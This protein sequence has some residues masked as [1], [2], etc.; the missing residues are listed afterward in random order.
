VSVESFS[1]GFLWNVLLRGD[2]QRIFRRHYARAVSLL[3]CNIYFWRVSYP[4]PIDW[5]HSGCTSRRCLYEKISLPVYPHWGCSYR[6]GCTNRDSFAASLLLAWGIC[7]LEWNG[8][9]SSRNGCC[10]ICHGTFRRKAGHLYESLRS[11]FWPRCPFDACDSQWSHRYK[12]VAFFSDIGGRVCPFIGMYME[13]RVR[14]VGAARGGGRTDGCT[15]S[16]STC[17][18]GEISKIQHPNVVSIGDFCV[19]WIRRQLEQ[20]SSEYIRSQDKL[21]FS[22]PQYIRILDRYALWAPFDWVDCPPCKLR[23]LFTWEHDDCVLVYLSPNPVPNNR[24]FVLSYIWYWVRNVSYLFHHNGVCESYVSR[25]GAPRYKCS[26]R[27]C[28][29][30]CRGIPFSDWLCNGPLSS[31]SGDV[32]DGCFYFYDASFIFNQLLLLKSYEKK[33]Y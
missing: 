10:L 9:I 20:L 4:P 23:A 5:I 24:G 29:S 28:W 32:G 21:L 27:I 15:Y 25:N 22:I 8:H 18:Q 6:C 3:S 2:D 19:C 13:N 1:L 12:L 31:K 11:G 26:H 33:F 16:G 7:N 14:F 17:F 30:W